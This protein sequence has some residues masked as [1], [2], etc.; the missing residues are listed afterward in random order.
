MTDDDKAIANRWLSAR[1]RYEAWG[2]TNVPQDPVKRA[3]ADVYGAKIKAEYNA[4]YDAY[5]A[6]IQRLSGVQR[7]G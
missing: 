1:M 2:M 7:A 4:A 5:Q 6:M 3:E